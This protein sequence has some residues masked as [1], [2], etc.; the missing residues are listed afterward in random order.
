MKYRTDF[1]TNSSSS[2]FIIAKKHL[3]DDQIEAIRSHS[4]LGEKLGIACSDE[5]WSIKE[6]E[7]FITGFAFMDN[8]SMSDLFDIIGVNQQV[9]FWGEYEFNLDDV[10]DIPQSY[11]ETTN[12]REF[13]HNL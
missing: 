1:V 7:D 3:D 2:S 12:W 11:G 13:L 5:P 10:E 6:D 8:F 4:L 9:V